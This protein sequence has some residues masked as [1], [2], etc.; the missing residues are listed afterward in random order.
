MNTFDAVFSSLRTFEENFTTKLDAVE[1]ECVGRIRHQ[2]TLNLGKQELKY[3]D[4]LQ[5]ASLRPY[6]PTP[7][8][9]GNVV[10]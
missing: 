6:K 3:Y 8:I 9:M 4:D 5:G 10:Y 2:H 1:D 7:A